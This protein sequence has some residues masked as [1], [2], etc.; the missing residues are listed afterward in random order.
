MCQQYNM[1]RNPD[2]DMAAEPSD[3]MPN[4]IGPEIDPDEIL[5]KRTAAIMEKQ[6]RKQEKLANTSTP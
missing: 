5:D 6:K 4:Y 2:K 1:N 3:F